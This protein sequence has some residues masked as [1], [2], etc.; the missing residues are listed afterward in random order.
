MN[1]YTAQRL[2]EERTARFRAE[3]A[4]RR[5]AANAGRTIRHMTGWALIRIGLAL[6]TSS[7]PRQHPAVRPQ[8]P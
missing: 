3:A 1:P 6:V 8:L 4:Q 5:S 7:A 2:T